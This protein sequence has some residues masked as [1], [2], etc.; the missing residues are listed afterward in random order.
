MESPSRTPPPTPPQSPSQIATQID[1]RGVATLTIQ[2]AAR[3][4]ALSSDTLQALITAVDELQQQPS[5]R[6]LIV[7]GEG[8]RAFVGGADIHQM[9]SLDRSGARAFITLVHQANHALRALSV[10]SIA[11]IQGFCLGAGMELA[12]ACDM[13]V[14]SSTSRY[15]MPEV[16]LG[17]P[18]VVE[19]SLLP[20]LVGEGKAR[21]W[22]YRGNI[23]AAQEAF[24]SRFLQYLVPPEE[25]DATIAP[26][27]ADILTADAEAVRQ[28]KF[29]AEYWVDGGV[30][31]S[32]AVSIE[33]LS[34]AAAR[35]STKARMQNF[36]AKR[37]R[38]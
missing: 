34:R 17:L 37:S 19:A 1:A 26:I 30:S 5:L 20:R 22:L 14:G 15:G 38:A 31:G 23:F 11:R 25:L 13:R 32:T 16:Q 9:A 2:G 18:S 36:I 7:T 33:E 10:P 27:V 24:E 12:A 28:Q 35:P 8:E 6:L 3:L 4:N 21:E 29:L